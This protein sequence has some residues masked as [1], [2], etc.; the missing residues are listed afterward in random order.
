MIKQMDDLPIFGRQSFHRLPNKR[1][2]FLVFRNQ[3][4]LQFVGFSQGVVFDP[5]FA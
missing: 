5:I 4:I 2:I 3:R 1:K